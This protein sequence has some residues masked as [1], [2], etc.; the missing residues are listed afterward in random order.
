MASRRT[1]YTVQWTREIEAASPQEA[2]LL[3]YKEQRKQSPD[4]ASYTVID[5]TV[6]H[7]G[8]H[9]SAVDHLEMLTNRER[10]VASL[11]MEGASNADIA[12]EMGITQRTV[13]AHL[14]HIFPKFNVR[15]RVNLATK[16]LRMQRQKGRVAVEV[17][18][19]RGR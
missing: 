9:I 8:V 12:E 7:R 6:K 18:G 14:S 3:A 19:I 17:R 15:N 2:A 16:L 4:S 1:V 13:K 11:V 10:E 5:G